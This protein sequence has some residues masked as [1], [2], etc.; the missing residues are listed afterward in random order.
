MHRR[1]VLL[2]LALS[3]A[4]PAAASPERTVILVVPYPPA[5][6]TEL[7]ARTLQS[8]WQ[9]RLGGTWVLENRADANRHDTA[10]QAA[11]HTRCQTLI[12]SRNMKAD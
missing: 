10:F 12:T 8:K 2:V 3:C 5:G 11:E 7:I 6:S 4:L 1:R 9:Q